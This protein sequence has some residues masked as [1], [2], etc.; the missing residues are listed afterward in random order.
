MWINDPNNS[1]P[2]AVFNPTGH[3][4]LYY[5]GSEKIRTADKGIQVGTGVTVETNG[6]ATF[7]GIVTAAS[8]RGDGSQLSGISVDASALK[9]PNGNIKIQAQASGAVHVGLS[10]IHI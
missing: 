9:D 2:S 5:I 8:F 6:Q 4:A 1:N 7:T 10:L 3:S